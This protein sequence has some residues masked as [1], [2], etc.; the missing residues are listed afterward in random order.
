MQ[1]QG[2]DIG[3]VSKAVKNINND[4]G[5]FANGSA[6][7]TKKYDALGVSLQNSDG[8]MKSTE[9]VLLDSIDALANMEDTANQ[10]WA[11]LL[12]K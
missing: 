10:T 12:K 2:T 6:E 4:L 3:A 1:R 9:D 11:A 5:D 7:A 8:T